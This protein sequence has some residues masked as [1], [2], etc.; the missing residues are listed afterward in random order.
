MKGPG[1]VTICE[2]S[3]DNGCQTHLLAD[4][5]TKAPKLEVRDNCHL[6]KPKTYIDSIGDQKYIFHFPLKLPPGAQ[7]MSG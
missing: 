1:T 4:K 2:T 3:L 5:R 7:Q 6:P